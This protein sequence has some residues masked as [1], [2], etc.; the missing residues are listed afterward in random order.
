MT[1]QKPRV[2]YYNIYPKLSPPR[3]RNDVIFNEMKNISFM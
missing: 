2:I 3:C 1:L